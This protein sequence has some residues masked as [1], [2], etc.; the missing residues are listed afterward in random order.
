MICIAVK[1]VPKFGIIHFPYAQK[2]NQTYWG[3]VDSK[4]TSSNLNQEGNRKSSDK[5]FIISRSHR[6]KVENLIRQ[7]YGSKTEVRN[8]GGAG[9]KVIQ[10]ITGNAT[11]Y[12]HLTRIKKWDICAGKS[13]IML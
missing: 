10:V 11:V 6:G 13:L 12:A 1:G 2:P 9:Y 5:V 7:A 4:V 3:Y 8:A